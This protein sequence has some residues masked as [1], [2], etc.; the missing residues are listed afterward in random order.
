MSVTPIDDRTCRAFDR[1]P[2][3]ANP[4]ALL[5]FVVGEDPGPR[6]MS[7]ADMAA[8][9]GDP[10]ATLLLR[11]GT[12]PRTA[13]A[14]LAGIDDATAAGDPLRSQMTFLLSEGSQ[15]PDGPDA[16]EANRG[17]RFIIAR[18]SAP[19]GIDLLVSAASPTAGV[20]EVMAWDRR[21]G[22]FN[23]YRTVSD[24]RAWAFAGN[25]RHAISAATG[26]KGPFES[27]PSGSLL[28]KELK[29]PWLHWHSPPANI[30]ARAFEPGDERANHRWF[31]DKLGAD[32]LETSVAIPSID[33]WTA[34]RFEGL[35]GADG[36]F[37]RPGRVVEQVV[38][39][40]TVNIVTS[41]RSSGAVTNGIEVDLPATFFVDAD[42]LAGPQ[43]GL[44]APPGFLVAGEHYLAALE[45]FGSALVDRTTG[46][47]HPR[48][49]GRFADTHFAFAVPERAFEDQSTPRAAIEAGLLT[50]RLAACLLMVDFPNPV[51]SSRRAALLAHA[52]ATAPAT[53]AYS[54]EMANRILAAAD[55]AGDGSPEREFADRWAA[56]AD[57]VAPFDALLQAYYDAVTARLASRAGYFDV[58][59]LAESRRL[60]V[61]AMPIGAEFDLLFAT[62]R[63]DTAPRPLRMTPTATIDE[64][65]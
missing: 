43:L 57:F 44:A 61:R 3:D 8:E 25:S 16:R 19:D 23:L 26:G 4:G 22:G 30:F 10:F 42:A 40:P 52:P 15:L 63:D 58:V 55:A 32:V 11:A 34:K 37:Q 38:T 33:R 2:S 13:E 36:S 41:N 20:I 7:N 47:R 5:R 31:K 21:A 50:P 6:P 56:G 17:M 24:G 45:Q 14:L 59:R 65:T 35:I 53:A 51:F 54:E 60:R 64:E 9:L 39:T 12:F 49:P 46:F 62:L 18:G 27:H 48:E 28:M 29:F 1:V